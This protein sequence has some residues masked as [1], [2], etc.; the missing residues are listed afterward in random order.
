[1]SDLYQKNSNGGV[2]IFK[3][4][5]G[6]TQDGGANKINLERL[7]FLKPNQTLD[8]DVVPHKNGYEPGDYVS[9]NT[10]NASEYIPLGNDS[11]T[12]T[13]WF[14]LRSNNDQGIR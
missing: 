1:M 4:I 14:R 12:L 11:R 5:D 8:L 10:S 9:I 13:A 2:Y 7:I 3:I 6:N